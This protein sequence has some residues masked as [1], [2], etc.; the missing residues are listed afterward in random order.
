MG[1]KL[2]EPAVKAAKAPEKGTK[3][4][5]DDHRDAP[6]GFGLKLSSVARSDQPKR[7]FI[8]RY[9]LAG[10]D[11]QMTIGE[12]PTWSVEAA[13]ARAKELRRE[14]DDGADP[15][16]RR[17]AAPRLLVVRT[18]GSGEVD[19]GDVQADDRKRSDFVRRSG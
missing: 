8:I 11:R 1:V 6:R 3:Y 18:P 12:W 19:V 10:A 16:A 5:F 7:V 17:R 4:L 2:S 13:R 15:L 14:I 9:K